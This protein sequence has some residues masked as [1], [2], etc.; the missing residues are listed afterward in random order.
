MHDN[1]GDDS[2]P[3]PRKKFYFETTVISHKGVHKVEGERL[4]EIGDTVVIKGK[5][6][7]IQQDPVERTIFVALNN[8]NEPY[9]LLQR[10]EDDVEAVLWNTYEEY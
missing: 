4:L 1:W 7:R 2:K 9:E 8:P 3:K 10:T 6:Y 5:I